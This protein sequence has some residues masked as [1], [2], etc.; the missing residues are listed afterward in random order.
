MRHCLCSL[1]ALYWPISYFSAQHHTPVTSYRGE[2]SHRQQGARVLPP[3][4]EPAGL[5]VAG[6]YVMFRMDTEG[7]RQELRLH[8]ELCVWGGSS[9]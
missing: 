7:T 8:L 4:A 5:V 6:L 9:S 3:S 1:L 2:E